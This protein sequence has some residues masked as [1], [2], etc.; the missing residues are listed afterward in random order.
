M[1]VPDAAGGECGVGEHP[2]A[3]RDGSIALEVLG[4]FDGRLEWQSLDG[5][6]RIQMGFRM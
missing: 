3:D 5:A 1:G 6:V 4:D 2:G